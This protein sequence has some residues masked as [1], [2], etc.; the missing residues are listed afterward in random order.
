MTRMPRVSDSATFSAG[1]RQT[2]QR[3]NSASPSFHSPDWRSK[4]RGVDATVKL[5]TAAPFGRK[6]SSGSPVRFPTTVTTVSPAMTSLLSPKP[7]R[8]QVSAAKAEVPRRVLF[9]ARKRV[10]RVRV[11][12]RASRRQREAGPTLSV[13]LGPQDLGPQHGFVQIQ[14][15]VELGHDVGLA[16]HVDDGVD[17][18]DLLLDLVREPPAA[19][20]VDLLHRAAAG[21]DDVEELVE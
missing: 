4:V 16:L 5:A 1:C 9:L 17:P 2:L 8:I 6:R 18:F 11:P 20:H 14:L 12:R 10:P 21:A 7:G 3:R 13:D 19:P 15:P